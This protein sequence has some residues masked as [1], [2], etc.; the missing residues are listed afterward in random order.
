M[1][2]RL[3][4]NLSEPNVVNK[5]LLPLGVLDGTLREATSVLNPTFNIQYID[6]ILNVNYIYV[7]EF[8][9]YYFVGDIASVV[10]NLW[11][12]SCH[13]DVLTTYKDYLSELSAIIARQE[14]NYNLYLEDDKFL[15]NAQRIYWTKAFPNQVSPGYNGRSFILTLAGGEDV[16][17]ETESS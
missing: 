3:Y 11:S 1:T 7:E 12:L 4:Q 9:R 17:K 13:V 10:N 2:I 15:I 16:N 6:L 14:N 5:N 8:K